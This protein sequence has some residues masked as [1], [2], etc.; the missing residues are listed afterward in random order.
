MVRAGRR[1]ILAD[2][3]A[4]TIGAVEPVVAVGAQA[5][6]LAEPERG[7]VAPMRHELMCSAALPARGAIPAMNFRTM[8][9]QGSMSDK[10]AF[11]RDAR[12]GFLH[13]PKKPFA[14]KAAG[15]GLSTAQVVVHT[16]G[17]HFC[18]FAQLYPSPETSKTA[19]KLC[20]MCQES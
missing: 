10:R 3:C 15:C 19:A 13:F 1:A 9:H 4:R 8:R 12:H 14:L 18:L 6:E 7:E 11:V 20:C 5:A 16:Y 17:L 2:R